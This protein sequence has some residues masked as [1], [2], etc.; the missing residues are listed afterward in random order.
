[1]PIYEYECQACDSKR[2]LIRVLSERDDPVR[3]LSC[4][5]P[6]QRILSQSS[7]ILKG[8]GWYS[9]DYKKKE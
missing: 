5:K 1:V 2:E 8:S 6:M 7:F 9:T 4:E 3:C